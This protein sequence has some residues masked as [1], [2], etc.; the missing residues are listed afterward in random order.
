MVFTDTEVAWITGPVGEY[1]VPTVNAIIDYVSTLGIVS[2]IDGVAPVYT[3]RNGGDYQVKLAINSTYYGGVQVSTIVQNGSTY[4]MADAQQPDAGTLIG[5]VKTQDNLVWVADG[6]SNYTV[7]TVNA[8]SLAL[9]SAIYA[10]SNYI[11]Y[12]ISN[13][14]NFYL[15]TS[16]DYVPWSS[17]ID[18]TKE[19]PLAFRGG[20]HFYIYGDNQELHGY[21]DIADGVGWVDAQYDNFG[22]VITWNEVER[23]DF[24]INTLRPIV[25]GDNNGTIGLQG[26]PGDKFVVPTV[27][28]VYD[29]LMELSAKIPTVISKNIY[30]VSEVY[31]DNH[32]YDYHVENH[33]TSDI[34]VT[35]VSEI[36][37]H[38]SQSSTV[39]VTYNIT[40]NYYNMVSVH[41]GL[42]SRVTNNVVDIYGLPATMA[43]IGMVFT[44]DEIAWVTGP[45]GDYTV[46]TVNAVSKALHG[47]K[48]ELD[49]YIKYEEV[50]PFWRN[51]VKL[52]PNPDDPKSLVVYAEPVAEGTYSDGAGAV[53]GVVATINTLPKEELS[54]YIDYVDSNG[55]Q[56]WQASAADKSLVPTANA[57]IH[58]IGDVSTIFGTYTS[59]VFGQVP[60]YTS[61]SG[62]DYL[63]KLAIDSDFHNGVR[64]STITIGGSTYLVADANL[65]IPNPENSGYIKYSEV[66]ES[67]YNNTRLIKNTT[68]P[69]KLQVFTMPLTGAADATGAG[70]EFGIVQTIN[71]VPTSE[72]DPLTTVYYTDSTGAQAPIDRAGDIV[73]VPTVNAVISRFGSTSKFI[74]TFTSRVFGTA[75]VYTSKSG[76]DYLIT[77]AVD[78]SY[79]NNV[80]LSTITS[81]GSTY[82]MA[83]ANISIPNPESY[84][85]IKYTEVDESYYNGVK[86]VTS[87]GNTSK[88]SVYNLPAIDTVTTAGVGGSYGVVKTINTIPSA[89]LTFNLTYVNST[90]GN[91]TLASAA[92][93][94]VVPTVNAVIN[95]IG[96]ISTIFGNYISVVSGIAPIYTSKK[97]NSAGVWL[98]YNTDYHGGV[99]VST[100]VSN[101]S[102]Y[103]IGDAQQPDAGTLLGTVK[104]QSH[105][106]WVSDGSSNY[107]VPTVNAV[108]LA[109]TSAIYAPSNVY[110]YNISNVSN[111]FIGTSGDYIPWDNVADIQGMGAYAFNLGAHFVKYK[112]VL[113]DK[114]TWHLYALN[115]HT[116][117]EGWKGATHD[118]FGV[119]IAWNQ[120]S[121]IN[122]N[123]NEHIPIVADNDY[124][125]TLP[126]IDFVGNPGDQYVVPTVNAVYDALMALS[127]KIPTIVSQNIY[128]VSEVYVTHNSYYY[129]TY[130]TTYTYPTYNITSEIHNH[131][132]QN[133]TYYITYQ[134][135]SQ[136][137]HVNTVS[138]YSGI[139]SNT[140]G[141][142]VRLYGLPATYRRHGMVITKNEIEYVPGAAG[143]YT[144]PTVNAISNALYNGIDDLTLVHWEQIGRIWDEEVQAGLI[145]EFGAYLY[146]RGVDGA[147]GELA[148]KDRKLYAINMPAVGYYPGNINWNDTVDAGFGVVCP[149]R[150]VARITDPIAVA[151]PVH[152]LSPNDVCI[153]YVGNPGDDF[154]VPTVNAVADAI[155]TVSH[156]AYKY[157]YGGQTTYYGGL[158]EVRTGL[159]RVAGYTA[160]NGVNYYNDE[161]VVPSINVLADVSAAISTALN[162]HI[163]D[164]TKHQN[165]TYGATAPISRNDTANPPSFGFRYSDDIARGVQCGVLNNLF[166][167]SGVPAQ[168]V[169]VNT[170]TT[171]TLGVVKVY[172][173]VNYIATNV[174]TDGT[175]YDYQYTVPTLNALAA[176][177]AALSAHDAN[178]TKHQNTTYTFETTTY[179]GVKLAYNAT[180]RYVSAVGVPASSGTTAATVSGTFALG[181]AEVHT[182]IV[183][184][185]NTESRNDITGYLRKD[186]AVPS[187]NALANVSAALSAHAANTGIHGGGGGQTYDAC[188]PV[189]ISNTNSICISSATTSNTGVVIL[190]N[191]L[192][193]DG[194]PYACLVPTASAVWTA[195]G[196]MGVGSGGMRYPNY[197]SAGGITDAHGG[198]LSPSGQVASGTAGSGGCWLLVSI[199]AINGAMGCAGVSINGTFIPLAGFSDGAITQLLPIPPGASWAVY[200]G[201]GSGI[202]IQVRVL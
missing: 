16:G 105:L 140:A 66:D 106:L 176:V 52:I 185:G 192:P 26:N 63:V 171:W 121:R 102:T 45:V 159:D 110:I 84:G 79:H 56:A 32:Y 107:T 165:T 147:G 30:I 156:F 49:G 104:T 134:F 113:D 100:L 111:F 128:I 153:N 75:P 193:A 88:L 190:T 74:C 54:I 174:K 124:P 101:N 200:N 93:K 83:D 23:I 115:D 72:L 12:N 82:L 65:D 142:I 90:G 4:L 175:Y 137:Y 2:K 60:V 41:S 117:G 78:S 97:D 24:E 116:D 187:V 191:S 178:T 27:N 108:S 34:Y 168:F 71:A 55:N 11:I 114:N 133:S 92:D 76:Y 131:I 37:N 1:T 17:V 31:V 64:V 181:V 22:T 195:L 103:L 59:R 95:R 43:N 202:I 28:A 29:A 61:R 199:V 8:V 188:P 166:K 18:A 180:N 69:K 160:I 68:D 122:V 167:V 132:S 33:Y 9:T 120:I 81:G 80:R 91:V 86:L 164:N 14:S 173:G 119:V 123:V 170:N 77:L 99:R 151:W 5:T 38:I 198:S 57:V 162:A 67:W 189:Y 148:P 139:S 150:Y 179:T 158:V 3:S 44:K 96:A 58:A 85:F 130:P 194:S 182:D 149:A 94:V 10:P 138:A 6:S 112:P 157:T 126:G 53:Y 19:N 154:V 136:I 163:N 127:A 177:S 196:G 129:N 155:E 15:G 144:V 172:D 70:G 62:N 46:P 109:L 145:Q 89:P 186:Y 125:G 25:P 183:S 135:N 152:T 47:L 20:A 87:F 35:Q 36:H 98:A 141:N 146:V 42:S 48:P 73:L 169:T 197:G 184:Y 39:N 161:H 118:N 13:I 143:S 201:G 40:S 50:D 7:P 21:N 51:G